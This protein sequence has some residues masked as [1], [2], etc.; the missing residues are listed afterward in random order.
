ML[1]RVGGRP[2]VL[3]RRALKI[4]SFRA[5]VDRVLAGRAQSQATHPLA[6]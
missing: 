3:T 2:D 5:Y 4:H 1:G 6:I